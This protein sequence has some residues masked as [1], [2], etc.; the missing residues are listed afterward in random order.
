[1]DENE[2]TPRSCFISTSVVPDHLNPNHLGARDAVPANTACSEVQVLDGDAHSELIRTTPDDGHNTLA[3]TPDLIS[4][5]IAERLAVF[6]GNQDPG[7][8]TSDSPFQHPLD[9]R[10]KIQH[11]QASGD[12]HSRVDNSVVAT[13]NDILREPCAPIPGQIQHGHVAV[14]NDEIIPNLYNSDMDE[15]KSGGIITER[16]RWREGGPAALE[17]KV[18]SEQIPDG[19]L[20]DVGATCILDSIPH[21]SCQRR[22]GPPIHE[23][24]KFYSFDQRQRLNSPCQK[25]P[26]EIDREPS[27][28]FAQLPHGQIRPVPVTPTFYS[29]SHPATQLPDQQVQTRHKRNSELPN[30]VIQHYETEDK[31]TITVTFDN[32][33]SGVIFPLA[34]YLEELPP[35]AP[36]SRRKMQS[37]IDDTIQALGDP[38]LCPRLPSCLIPVPEFFSSPFQPLATYPGDAGPSPTLVVHNVLKRSIA[39]PSAESPPSRIRNDF[40]KPIASAPTPSSHHARS[41]DNELYQDL[42]TEPQRGSGRVQ[43]VCLLWVFVFVLLGILEFL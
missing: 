1:M 31:S 38:L 10:S 43:L 8:D 33:P 16:N 20:L 22:D 34:A 41:A 12:L 29:V 2:G 25:N 32:V 42:S 35:A 30:R 4:A 37:M 18:Y 24:C 23:V 27:R 13:G 11:A 28:H 9:T 17:E 36:T 7:E 19:Q 14:N 6:I 39:G 40:P 3:G 26:V 5:D 21:P 15:I